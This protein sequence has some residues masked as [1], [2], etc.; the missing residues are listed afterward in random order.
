M[1]REE[2]I[3]AKSRG[4]GAES[5]GQSAK[6]KE[7]RAEGR[8]QRAEG[9]EQWAGSKGLRAMGRESGAE[10][11]DEVKLQFFR[12]NFAAGKTGRINE[13][14]CRLKIYRTVINN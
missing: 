11:R 7:P 3:A 2:K 12:L 4:Q 14:D 6:G 9:R 5:K 13:N 8:E 1:K 10:S